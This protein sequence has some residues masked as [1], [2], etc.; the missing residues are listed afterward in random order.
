M[1]SNIR[2]LISYGKTIGLPTKMLE[3]VYLNNYALAFHN[4]NSGA[5]WTGKRTIAFPRGIVK[6]LDLVQIDGIHDEARAIGLLFHEGTHA[7]IDDTL[8]TGDLEFHA[9]H[10]RA[11]R[12]YTN[13]KFVDGSPVPSAGLDS[14]VTEAAAWYVHENV[15]VWWMA[16]EIMEDLSRGGHVH[17]G[18]L[19][20]PMPIHVLRDL[21]FITNYARK[22][23]F[24][25]S[26][27]GANTDDFMRLAEPIHPGL[28]S[29]CD[30]V[31]L[32]GKI[33]L[34]LANFLNVLVANYA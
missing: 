6:A 17:Q 29:Y 18:S 3:K 20:Y 9:L 26:W 23:N 24:G 8:K 31:V 22:A 25:V 11:K 21:L 4:R 5:R 7:L 34:N 28:K 27:A 15:Y 12:H 1:V 10:N 14:A 30:E 13:A 2:F 32:E 33:K 19:V 16:R